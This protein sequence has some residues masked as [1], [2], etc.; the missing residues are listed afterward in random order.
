MEE[1]KKLCKNLLLIP[2]V[3]F[4]EH[5]AFLPV[6]IHHPPSNHTRAAH[7]LFPC[8]YY[9]E[10]E[11]IP[12]PAPYSEC[13]FTPFLP[14]SHLPTTWSDS[15]PW[16]T[17][18]FCSDRLS[19]PSFESFLPGLGCQSCFRRQIILKSKAHPLALFTGLFHIVGLVYCLQEFFTGSHQDMLVLG[20]PKS[21]STCSFFQTEFD[22][23]VLMECTLW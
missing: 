4:L 14:L 23:K 10:G 16:E 15:S 20:L 7:S 9:R 2:T 22:S 21:L 6:S 18:H 12:S 8:S 5:C 11:A 1:L 17:C 19:F 13:F 3:L